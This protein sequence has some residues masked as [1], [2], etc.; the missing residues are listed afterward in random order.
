VKQ[1][2]LCNGCDGLVELICEGR[3]MGVMVLLVW[4]SYCEG[5]SVGVMVVMV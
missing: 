4:W 1:D 3:K 5:R 2:S